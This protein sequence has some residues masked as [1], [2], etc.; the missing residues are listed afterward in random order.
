MKTLPCRVGLPSRCLLSVSLLTFSGLIFAQSATENNAVRLN[1]VQKV[2]VD[3][4]QIKVQTGVSMV[5]D[6]LSAID[7]SGHDAQSATLSATTSAAKDT[8]F[9][10]P[11]PDDGK[12]AF[13]YFNL[14]ALDK[15]LA[16]PW[17]GGVFG[18]NPAMTPITSPES[19]VMTGPPLNP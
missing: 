4:S 7:Y 9:Q 18:K 5:R 14:I 10:C 15:P 11:A 13:R 17:A 8:W 19:A 2:H 1:S 3:L 12:N 16:N 6:C